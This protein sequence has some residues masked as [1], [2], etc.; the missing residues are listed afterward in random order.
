LKV[1][2]VS[3]RQVIFWLASCCWMRVTISRAVMTRRSRKD[4]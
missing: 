4:R 1:S 3:V 2:T